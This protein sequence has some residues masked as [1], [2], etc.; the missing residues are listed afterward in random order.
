MRVRARVKGNIL[1]R[2]EDMG[3][4]AAKKMGRLI[5]MQST[6]GLRVG[7]IVNDLGGGLDLLEVTEVNREVGNYENSVGDLIRI[8]L[9]SRK[10]SE[11]CS[12]HVCLKPFNSKSR[13]LS[14]EQR[15]CGLVPPASPAVT[16]S[17]S[18]QT[19]PG[20]I[21]LFCFSDVS[22]STVQ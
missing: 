20:Q 2:G 8:W 11:I 7:V 21:G 18:H 12:F 4:E 1:R 13:L 3:L 17:Q 9:G 22:G 10:F 6:M 5:D 19:E 14:T 16:L 15:W